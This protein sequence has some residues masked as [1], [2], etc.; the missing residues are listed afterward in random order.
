MHVSIAGESDVKTCTQF[1]TGRGL[2]RQSKRKHYGDHLQLEYT[3]A[4][5]ASHTRAH[6][7]SQNRSTLQ[8]Y[9]AHKSF[10]GRLGVLFRAIHPMPPHPRACF[11]SQHITAC[12]QEFT[13]CDSGH[14]VSEEC[15]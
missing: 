1:S 4:L 14:L 12:D 13:A 15:K 9:T 8:V 2:M 6:S 7:A 5:R 10:S 3:L 11:S